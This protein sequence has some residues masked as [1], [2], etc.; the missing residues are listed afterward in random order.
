MSARKRP[1]K[2]P[3]TKPLLFTV[4]GWRLF[5]EPRPTLSD[6]AYMRVALMSATCQLAR[7]AEVYQHNLRGQIYRSREGLTMITTLEGELKVD[8]RVWE[9]RIRAKDATSPLV[10]VPKIPVAVT[11]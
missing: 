3:Y 8:D 5:E 7:H 1:A 11:P 6:D 10:T 2:K 9:F 4:E